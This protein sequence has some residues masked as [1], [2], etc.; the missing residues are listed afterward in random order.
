MKKIDMRSFKNLDGPI[1]LSKNDVLFQAGGAT[2]IDKEIQRRKTKLPKDGGLPLIMK[3]KVAE[4]NGGLE[5]SKE[6]DIQLLEKRNDFK[7]AGPVYSE[8]VSVDL[9]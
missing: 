9:D 2:A 1:S 7:Q 3:G 6:T 5:K 4:I 8:A